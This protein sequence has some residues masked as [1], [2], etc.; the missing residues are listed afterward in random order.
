[1]G[2]GICKQTT[3]ICLE[4]VK[5]GCDDENLIKIS[6]EDWEQFK[7]DNPELF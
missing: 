4:A 6:K 5:N 1:M 7:K 3:E 2:V